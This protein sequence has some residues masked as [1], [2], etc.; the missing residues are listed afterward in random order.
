MSRLER[1]QRDWEDLATLDPLWAIA[2][3]PEHRFGAWDED[4]FMASGERKAKGLM[5]HLDRLGL[6]ARRERALD[7]GCGVGR[8]TL[9][10]STHFAETTGV[11]IAPAMIEQA[12]Q[13]A[14]GRPGV[15]YVLNDRDD[16]EVL[17]GERFDLVYTGL[18]LQHQPSRATALRYLGALAQLVG[19]GGVLVAQLPVAMT[20]RLRLQPGRRVYEALRR[21]GVPRDTLYKRLRLQPM[22][23]TW[24]PRA[25]V[26]RCLAAHGLAIV[27]A[28][29]RDREGVR[30][31]TLYATASGQE[32][33]VGQA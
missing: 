28:D 29:E 32:Q 11:D 23:M 13:R 6:P 1:H 24:I 20:M 9:P 19:P 21:L 31:L 17:A 4:A 8:I 2:S 7:F 14:A 22:R 15:R 10:L 12:R 16:L 26:E 3:T 5:S 25:E 18:V 33:E 27:D 30:S